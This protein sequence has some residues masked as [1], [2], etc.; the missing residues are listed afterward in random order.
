MA[1]LVT[2]EAVITESCYILRGLHGAA[3]RILENVVNGAFHIPFQLSTEAVEV[4]RILRRYQ[5]REIDFADAC[6]I[7]FANQL[8]SGEILTLD[9]DFEIYRWGG[10]KH[11][12][13]LIP[14][15]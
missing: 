12:D 9:R 7:Q 3:E 6:L 2:C 1:T 5:D 14:L 10:A 11:F 13:L 4:Q 8:R 15:R